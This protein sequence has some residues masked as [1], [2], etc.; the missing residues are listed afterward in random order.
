MV[1]ENEQTT[2]TSRAASGGVKLGTVRF[3]LAISTALAIVAMIVV[4]TII[5]H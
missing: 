2:I 5:A 4:F 3:V 1:Q